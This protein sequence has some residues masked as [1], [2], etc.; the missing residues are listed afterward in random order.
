MQVYSR[1]KRVPNLYVCTPMDSLPGR[2]QSSRQR[3]HVYHPCLWAE[4]PLWWVQAGHG[5]VWRVGRGLDGWW[6]DGYISIPTTIHNY[7]ILL[8]L[9][10]SF[11]SNIKTWMPSIPSALLL[12]QT[13]NPPTP[14]SY[15]YGVIR[16]S[17][18]KK[19]LGSSSNGQESVAPPNYPNLFPSD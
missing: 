17:K 13:P 2:R 19:D 11:H 7:M 6:R 1:D 12:P 10:P 8:S 4:A 5:T 14:W 15:F 3:S 9:N 16:L 18:G